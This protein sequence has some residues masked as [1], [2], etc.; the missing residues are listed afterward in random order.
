MIYF[1]QRVEF[2]Y[3]GRL[4]AGMTGGASYVVLP[5]FLSEIADDK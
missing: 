1:V 5:T 4:L 2:L 3:V